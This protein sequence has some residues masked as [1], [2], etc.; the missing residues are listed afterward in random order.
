MGETANDIPRPG[1][2]CAMEYEGSFGRVFLPTEPAGSKFGKREI[3]ITCPL[4]LKS[5]IYGAHFAYIEDRSQSDE[6]KGMGRA[7]PEGKSEP[8]DTSYELTFK[9]TSVPPPKK[10]W[11]K[12]LPKEPLS[13]RPKKKALSKRTRRCGGWH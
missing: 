13:R 1:V 7:V 10:A 5:G 9:Q 4:D 12:R 6:V 2:Q 11:S 3:I 8:E